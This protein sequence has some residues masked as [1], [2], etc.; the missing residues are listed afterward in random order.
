MA[1][2]TTSQILINGERNAVVRLTCLSDGTAE[3]G[4]IKIDATKNGPFGS[5][6]GGKTFF[7]LLKFR[8]EGVM[9]DIKNMG[10]RIQWEGMPSIDALVLANVDDFDFRR[11]GGIP[12]DPTV[13]FPTGN[14]VFTTVGAVAG[15][16]YSVILRLIK[17]IQS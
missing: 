16:S 4:V 6:I 11:W 8:I 13:S 2:I 1:N 10:L 17:D 7:P 9:Y 3:T 12:M 5:K 15:S 14:I